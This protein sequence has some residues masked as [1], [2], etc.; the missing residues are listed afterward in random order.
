M[1]ILFFLCKYSVLLVVFLFDLWFLILN[2]SNNSNS[3]YGLERNYFERSSVK[4]WKSLWSL[5]GGRPSIL[6]TIYIYVNILFNGV[7][8]STVIVDRGRWNTSDS[9]REH[10]ILWSICLTWSRETEELEGFTSLTFEPS[11]EVDCAFSNWQSR[12]WYSYS[13]FCVD[14]GRCWNL[15]TAGAKH[16]QRQ[17]LW[18]PLTM[19]EQLSLD[20]VCLCVENSVHLRAYRP[21]D[22]MEMGH[23]H[24]V[25]FIWEIWSCCHINV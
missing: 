15:Q 5:Q 16:A 8:P 17:D 23:F 2:G 9:S 13:M 10:R 25:I 11:L 21:G 24:E 6:N 18:I 20:Q 12:T 22:S 7:Y 4:F 19:E 1:K 14:V 3:C